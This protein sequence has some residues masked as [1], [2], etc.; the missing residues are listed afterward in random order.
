MKLSVVKLLML[1][2]IQGQ[3]AVIYSVPNNDNEDSDNNPVNA[4]L[5]EEDLPDIPNPVQAFVPADIVNGRK[6]RAIRKR[7]ATGRSVNI[8]SEVVQKMANVPISAL[9]TDLPENR[10]EILDAHNYFRGK[11]E[12]TASNMLKLVW[13]PE[14]AKTSQSWAQQCILGHSPQDNRKI[15]GFNCGEN[16][17]FFDYMVPWKTVIE[18]W[19]SENVDFKYGHGATSDAEIGHF[20]Q[21]MWA[22]SSAVGCG[23][24]E[25]KNGPAKYNFVCHYAP[26]GNKG[27][28]AKPWKQGK[29]CGDCPNS[30]ENNL[31]TN[32]CGY[33]D[34]F[35]N[36]VD[37]KNSCVSDSSMKSK[38]CPATCQCINGEIK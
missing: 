1:T 23:M 29:P 2:I 33:Q 35:N 5:D 15:T 25:C 36:C 32:P 28:R 27:S 3:I 30:C 26:S 10:K 18:S 12:P 7:S 17:F 14:A 6:R 34:F 16:I 37:F 24:A 22:S 31:C 9:S 19:Y 11:A 4:V 20:T 8:P 21:V 38:K 13:S